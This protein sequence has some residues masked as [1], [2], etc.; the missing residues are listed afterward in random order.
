MR[1]VGERDFDLPLRREPV[2][3]RARRHAASEVDGDGE[4]RPV[5]GQLAKLLKRAAEALEAPGEHDDNG[6]AL[7]VA[8]A[9]L[10]RHDLVHPPFQ[11]QLIE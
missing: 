1:R 6:R 7:G 8:L 2:E 10:G 9:Q 4:A 11:R 3:Q 5:H